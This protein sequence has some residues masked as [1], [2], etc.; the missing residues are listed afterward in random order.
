MWLIIVDAHSKWP[1]VI[2]TKDTSAENTAEILLDTFATHGLCEQIVSDNGSQFTSEIFK[3]FCEARG[4]QHTL[5][6]P[7][8]PQSNGE[9]ERF[10]QTFKTTMMKSKLSGEKMKPSLRN[11][12]ARYRVTP[13][14][15][16]G[17]APCELLMKR[18]LRTRLD[19]IQ[20]TSKGLV[21]YK[22]NA[23]TN[24]ADLKEFKEGD[25]VWVRNYRSGQKWIQGEIIGK[26]GQ[27]IYHVK[28]KKGTWRRHAH[29]LRQDKSQFK[30]FD[31]PSLNLP[32]TESD[33]RIVTTTPTDDST[34]PE[35][36]IRQYPL[37]D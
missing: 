26:I 11:F 6:A 35:T 4:I 23:D 34:S 9:A 18:H 22:N 5:T 12:L 2:P 32:T 1:T 3:K 31:I 15:T 17:I 10:V 14:C 28:V 8:H 29:Q 16:T 27:A 21:K 20:P 19:L 33:E 24:Q 13:H 25:R 7:F 37:R 36:S 30:D